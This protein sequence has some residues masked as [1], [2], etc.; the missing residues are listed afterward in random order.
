MILESIRDMVRKFFGVCFQKLTCVV[1]RYTYAIPLVLSIPVV[2]IAAYLFYNTINSMN[3]MN[4]AIKSLP[5]IIQTE[6]AKT[7]ETFR[8]EQSAT[9]ES[10]RVTREEVQEGMTRAEDERHQLQ[11]QLTSI[12][13]KVDTS[14]KPP[15]PAEQKRKKVLGIF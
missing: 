3:D 13:K 10:H 6:M 12:E 1:D 4:A 9:R 15:S 8:S 11:K 7:R 2:V 14:K 5:V